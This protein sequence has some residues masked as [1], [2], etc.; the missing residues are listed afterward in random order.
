[1]KEPSDALDVTEDCSQSTQM[2][3]NRDS[4]SSRPQQL[5]AAKATVRVSN[6][7]ETLQALEDVMN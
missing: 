2:S 7:A 1:V 4:M 6:W 5:T 3:H